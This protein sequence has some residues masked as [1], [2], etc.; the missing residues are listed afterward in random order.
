MHEG[1][2]SGSAGAPLTLFETA[3]ALVYDSSLFGATGPVLG[4]RYR[5]E[6]APTLGDL[7]MVTLSADYRRYFMP[8]RPVTIAV[9]VEH[10]GRYGDAAGDP[11]LLPL[12]WSI[13]DLVRGYDPYQVLEAQ[14]E[15]ERRAA[16]A[17]DWAVRPRIRIEYP[18]ARRRDLC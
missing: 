11:R 10:V 18:P 3:A 2:E 17:D 9:R 7:S 4:S 16:R 15:V 1:E 6:I 8:V 5:L 12:V 14:S 13:R